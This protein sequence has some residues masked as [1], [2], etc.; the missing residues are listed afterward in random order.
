MKTT[1]IATASL[2]SLFVSGCAYRDAKM[3]QDDTA[4]VL[5]TKEGD[6]RS[7]YDGVL[8][9]SP[10]TGGKVTLKWEVDTDGGKIT[11]V[12]VDKAN[13]TAP[14]PVQQCVTNAITGLVIS[15]PDRR[16]GQGTWVWEFNQP[17]G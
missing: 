8:K 6:I 7:C 10:G 1:L 9:G 4:K 14:E 11:K 17:K 15:P 16:V 3:W 12:E 5:K 2:A 13:T